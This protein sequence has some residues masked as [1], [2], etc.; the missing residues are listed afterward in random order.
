[1]RKK[2]R[3]WFRIIRDLMAAHIS[4][5]KIASACGRD[6][7][8]IEHW[9]EDGEPKDSDARVVLA[10]YAK[11]CPEKYAE[12][13]KEFSIPLPSPAMAEIIDWNTGLAS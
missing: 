11:F 5:A 9:T 10:L 2:R 13:M 12:H 3:D 1:M 8:T 6:P 4:M 7:K